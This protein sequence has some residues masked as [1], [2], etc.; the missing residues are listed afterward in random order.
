MG[1]PRKLKPQ[2]E[3]AATLQ[4]L[5]LLPDD[6]DSYDEEIEEFQEDEISVSQPKL[7]SLQ[8]NLDGTESPIDIVKRS[9]LPD[10]QACDRIIDSALDWAIRNRPV[11]ATEQAIKISKL[12]LKSSRTIND[13]LID[14]LNDLNPAFIA[15]SQDCLKAVQQLQ[16]GVYCFDLPSKTP[17]D[18]V[19]FFSQARKAIAQLLK[20]SED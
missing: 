3:L 14:P 16:K 19:V 1:R 2:A 17:E 15:R 12:L 11:P 9:L 6:T 18:A 10:F 8:L 20:F 13:H 4:D 5:S 7:K